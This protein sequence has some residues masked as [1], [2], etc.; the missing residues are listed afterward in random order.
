MRV[1]S[2]IIIAGIV[3]AL[4]ALLCLPSCRLFQVQEQ[5]S[6]P[7]SQVVPQQVVPENAPGAEAAGIDNPANCDYPI[8]T[9]GVRITCVIDGDTVRLFNGTRIRLIGIDAPERG[10][11]GFDNATFLLANL[12]NQ[13][14]IY[15]EKDVSNTDQYGRLLR[16]IFVNELFVNEV[17]V[18]YGWATVWDVPPDVKHSTVLHQA[19]TQAKDKKRGLWAPR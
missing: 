9:R 3:L 18:R 8:E 2:V 17:M 10:D 19:E 14:Y 1:R 5:E 6:I 7:Q 11:Y 4:I 12:T 13:S 16:N 15:L